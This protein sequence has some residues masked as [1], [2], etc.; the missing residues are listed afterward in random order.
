MGPPI[1]SRFPGYILHQS[2]MLMSSQH[3]PQIVGGSLMVCDWFA[4]HL[5]HTPPR[6]SK[7]L[8]CPQPSAQHLERARPLKN[9]CGRQEGDR[10]GHPGLTPT[11]GISLQEAA[12]AAPTM[13]AGGASPA[14][15]P[16]ARLPCMGVRLLSLPRSTFGHLSLP[17]QACSE[18]KGNSPLPAPTVVSCHHAG[19]P[20]GRASLS[21]TFQVKKQGSRNCPGPHSLLQRGS[22]PAG[23]PLLLKCSR[24]LKRSHHFLPQF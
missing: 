4:V 2:L 16:R 7:S 12:S 3:W 6:G 21:P 9:S 15:F 23:H 10:E 24:R 8:L 1:Q 11:C 19:H 22:S 18:A 5:P 13:P 20:E 17:L 14:S